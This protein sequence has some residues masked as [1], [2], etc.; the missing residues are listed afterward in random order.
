MPLFFLLPYILVIFLVTLQELSY[1]ATPL[2]LAYAN[3]ILLVCKH[4]FPMS[5]YA[6]LYA[7]I[8]K[9]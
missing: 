2:N 9:S 6:L 7:A 8:T 5:L 1:T 3:L 4:S